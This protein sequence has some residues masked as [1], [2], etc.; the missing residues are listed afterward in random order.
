MTSL[1]DLF[2]ALRGIV[3]ADTDTDSPAS[4]TASQSAPP[5]LLVGLG[6][7]GR[8]YRA[9]RHN[10]GFMAVD[11]IAERLGVAFTRTQSKALLTD[12]RYRERRIY[13][14][15]PQ[16]YMNRSGQAVAALVKFYKIP[17]ENLLVI[18]DD[19]DLPFETL[20]LRP[21]GGSAG[22]KGMRSIIEQLG[23]QEFPRL[24]L[25]VGRNF[26]SRQAADYVLKPFARPEREFLPAYLDRA[27]DAALAFVSEGIQQA[28]TIYNRVE[29]R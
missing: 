27:A 16:T 19:V 7:P 17:L 5:Y 26:G 13:L 2:N 25:G 6:N 20:R 21:A 22:H 24:R 29:S 8:E 15:K 11:R 1:D 10:I 28:M 4:E 23:T 14:A 3:T 12:A 9:T 18:Y